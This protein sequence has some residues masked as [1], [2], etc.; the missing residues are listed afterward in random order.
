LNRKIYK[1]GNNPKGMEQT[2]HLKIQKP[3][4]KI[5]IDIPKDVELLHSIIDRF[6]EYNDEGLI[7]RNDTHIP[8]RL[9][10]NYK[11]RKTYLKHKKAYVNNH[12]QYTNIPNAELLD[13][14][15]KEHAQI[16]NRKALKEAI[17]TGFSNINKKNIQA[18]IIH[19]SSNIVDAEKY[20]IAEKIL[21]ELP[22][23]EN[24]IIRTD[25]DTKT[26][27]IELYMFGQNIYE[28]PFIMF[29]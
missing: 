4:L 14:E 18:I 8:K 27:L 1:F 2:I 3:K 22:V 15:T 29:D 10:G 12:Y 13:T 21:Q 9:E 5:E 17:D 26:T 25:N 16:I 24:D 19:I 6:T 20:F 7:L 11:F 23:V 28:N